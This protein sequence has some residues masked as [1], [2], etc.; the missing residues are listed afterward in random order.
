MSTFESY[1]SQKLHE[2]RLFPVSAGWE[3]TLEA[4]RQRLGEPNLMKL[5]KLGAGMW[6]DVF[7]MSNKKKIVKLTR[8]R[9]DAQ[10]SLIVQKKPS[11]YLV[12]TYDV[13]S[14]T[15]DKYS[16]YCIVN[17]K[18]TPLAGYEER[19]VDAIREIVRQVSISVSG[20][21]LDITSANYERIK[22]VLD[23]E[24][25]RA[26][27]EDYLRI[28]ADDFLSFYKNLV[29]ALDDRHIRWADVKRPNFMMRGAQIVVADLG[30]GV[31]SGAPAI[32][33][34]QY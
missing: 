5:K 7:W 31:V 34:L 22:E 21:T 9:A 3:E 29:D 1:L 16:V 24:H 30:A 14:V 18:L 17:E 23:T 15:P 11:R 2:G 12:K 13:F 25:G 32:P 28:D 8:D 20:L 6:A 33:S 4:I 19:L 27:A 26:W 10:A